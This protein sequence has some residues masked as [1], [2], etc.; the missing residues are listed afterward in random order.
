[1]TSA[2]SEGYS[3]FGDAVIASSCSPFFQSQ[4]EQ[5]GGI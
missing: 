3:F 4:P 5:V 1:M 2:I